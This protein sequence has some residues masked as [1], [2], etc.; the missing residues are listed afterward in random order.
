MRRRIKLG[1]VRNS[2]V[3]NLPESARWP[4]IEA[5]TNN[6]HVPAKLASVASSRYT[7][8]G[9]QSEFRRT[10][11]RRSRTRNG[12]CAAGRSPCGCAWAGVGRARRDDGG[13]QGV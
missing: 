13:G 7:L 2:N 11:G 4:Q 8:A 12:G 5:A 3:R 9:K 10:H 6:Q 1:I